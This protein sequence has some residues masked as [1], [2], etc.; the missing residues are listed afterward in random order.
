MRLA[1]PIVLLFLVFTFNNS[2]YA[3]QAGSS[4]PALLTYNE[5]VALYENDPPSPDL[6]EKVTRLLR[7]PFVNNSAGVRAPRP[8]RVSTAQNRG[9]RVAT[10]N[11]ERGL[12]FDAVKAALTNDQRFFRR[13]TPALRGSKFNLAEI[14]EQA[15]A[16]SRADVVIL[17]EVD[18]G[19]KRTNYRNVAKEL[20]AAMQMNYVFGV[21]FI[22]VDPLTL[23]TETLEG[24]TSAE[25]AEI[26]K[27]IA[28]DKSRTLGLHGTAILSRFP[29][30]NSR[31]MPYVYQGHDWYHDEKDGVSKLETG[32]RKGAKLVFGEKIM[33]EVRRGGRMMLLADIA[34]ASI[35]GGAA[36]IVATHLEAKSKPSERLK[37]LD[38]LLSQIK[39]IDN[40]VV[41]AGDMNTSGSDATPTSFQREVK[42]RLGSTSFWATQGIKYAT[43]VGLIY[44][45]TVGLV[46]MQRTRNDPTVKSLKFVSENPEEKFFDTLKDFRFV[47]GRAFDFRGSKHHSIGASGETLSD[48]NE[49]GSKGFVS[50]LE[51]KGKFNVEMKL[52]W[53]FVK[54]LQLTDPDDRDQPY[55]FAPH[56]GRTLKTLNHSL[57]DGIS[58]H[59]PMIV[60][61]PLN[62]TPKALANSSP[63]LE[64]S[65]NPG[66]Q[67]H[68]KNQR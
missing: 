22:E 66:N 30:Q 11:I 19:L 36:T 55:T 41:L 27:N 48:S 39:S 9:L 51:L 35:P 42:K 20:A 28:V 56:F 24:E 46:K 37:Q 7:T 58:D 67:G 32:K 21:E 5:L 53:I 45:I 34:D 61:L 2:I 57:K 16:L 68:K 31:L 25:K 54:P 49:R 10:W 18:W 3:Q 6:L 65:D 38:E 50:T 15:A 64:R 59:N 62:L 52:D 4:G 23:G 8:G 1:V 63:G 40:P 29:L 12:E 26:I 33:R 60:D 44:D 43:G 13:L 14:L 17:N 47:D